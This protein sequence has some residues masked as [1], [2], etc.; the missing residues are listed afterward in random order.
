[1]ADGFKIGDAFAEV[2][3]RDNTKAGI[4]KIK[5]SLSRLD[6]TVRINVADAAALASIRRVSQ[7][8][9]GL[10]NQTVRVDVDETAALADVRRIKTAMDGLRNSNVRITINSAQAMAEIQRVRLALAGLSNAHVRVDLDAGAAFAQILALRAALAAL[11]NTTTVNVNANVSG[12]QAGLQGVS[13]LLASIPALAAVAGAAIAAIPAALGSLGAIGGVILGAFSGVGDALAGYKADQQAAG[14]ASAASGAAAAASARAIRDA[15]QAIVD[16]KEQQARAARA[17]AQAIADAEDQVQDAVTQAARTARD[18]A[19]AV[20]N[21]QKSLI[22]AQRDAARSAQQSADAVAAASRRVSDAA[23]AET[24]AQEDLNDARAEGLRTLEDL[25]FAAEDAALDQQGAALAL[26]EAQLRLAQANDSAI[27]T[28]LDKRK[29]LYDVAVAQQRVKESA[30]DATRATADNADAQAKGVDGLDE[31]VAAQERVQDAAQATIDAQADLVKAQQAAADAQVDSAERVADAQQAVTDAMTRQAEANADAQDRI[32][33]AQENLSRVR[34]DAADQQADAAKRVA[35]AEQRLK[36]AQDDAAKSATA[37]AG[38]ASKFAEAMK[39]LSPAAQAFVKQLIAMKP[40]VKGLSD[41]AAEA[42][43]PGLTLMLKDSTALFPIFNAALTST[44]TAMAATAIKFGDLFKSSTFQQNLQQMLQATLPVTAAIGDMFVNLTSK[45]VEFGAKMAPVALSF[46]DFVS[47]VSQGLGG[48]FDA[49]GQ[50]TSSFSSIWE[51]LGSIMQTLLPIVGQLVGAFADSV[52]PVLQ[53][54]AQWLEENKGAISTLLPLIAAVSTAFMSWKL[55][56]AVLTPIGGMITTAGTKIAALGT[57]VGGAD[58]KMAGFGNAVSKVGGALP[59]IGAAFIAGSLVA[60]HYSNEIDQAAAALLKGGT[61]AQQAQTQF[62][63]LSFDNFGRSIASTLPGLQLFVDN[64]LVAAQKAADNA[65]KMYDAMSPLE[66]AQ[67]RYTQAVNNFTKDSP[68]ARDALADLNEKAKE[69]DL[70]Q[71]AAAAGTDTHTQALADLNGQ[72]RS[73]LGGDVAYKQSLL[74]VKD[75]QEALA[76][77][78]RDKGASSDEAQ[79]AELRLV[80]TVSRSAEAAARKAEADAKA[81][82]VTDTAK[83]KTD[84][85]NVSLLSQAAAMD[86]PGQAALLKYT[87]SMTDAQLAAYSASAEASGFATKILTLPDGRKVTVVLDSAQALQ[88]ITDFEAAAT[89]KTITVKLDADVN[90]ATQKIDGTVDLGNGKTAT[91][92]LESNVDPATGK[93]NGVIDLGNGATATVTVDANPDPATGKVNATV[94]F[95]NGRTTVIQLDAD[96]AKGLDKVN[97][98]VGW[99][100]GQITTP[101]VDADTGPANNS[102][103]NWFNSIPKTI[104]VIAQT[105]FGNASGNIMMPMAEGGVLGYANGGAPKKLTPMSGSTASVVSPNTWRV[106][107][108]NMTSPELFAPLDGSKRSLGLIKY[109]AAAFGY[110]LTPVAS[111]TQPAGG[112]VPVMP[113]MPSAPTAMSPSLAAAQAAGQQ[114]VTH[115]HHNSITLQV[116]GVL[117]FSKGDAAARKVVSDLKDRLLDLE[118][119]TF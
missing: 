55:I 93:I 76:K 42:F 7:A 70:E 56:S 17:A 15:T 50:H 99:G 14:G 40:L 81:A 20:E 22:A 34:Q 113:A 79:R 100:N 33:D 49:L 114:I 47:G 8:L 89:A 103:M 13:M 6:G 69:A 82:G 21:A 95:G 67:V 46:A 51:S 38:A 111:A 84:A 68:Q 97:G 24:R 102:F 108:D 41:A 110:S 36:D 31:V 117:D 11:G 18:S 88:A 16:A 4:D 118:R 52:A 57:A 59:V 45:F 9:L 29:A 64:N 3:L 109:G 86:G 26:E 1:M 48:M 75:A 62:T 61:A 60:E 107:G 115:T 74:D 30:V 53:R 54:V 87:G 112:P 83:L 101:K 119:S 94:D 10:S 19:R 44:G 73:A 66:Q 25:A 78:V 65:K 58:S 39:K 5:D 71:R 2:E 43:L 77:A 98:F 37:G 80:D 106:I 23:R 96:Q 63:G 91:M 35:E 28:D 12:A 90:P 116:Q 104:S 105:I 32:A 85:Y 72:M 27:A 92:T